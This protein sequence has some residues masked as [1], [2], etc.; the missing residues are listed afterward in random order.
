MASNNSKDI[1]TPSK[2]GQPT[3][4]TEEVMEKLRQAFLI[5]AS[6]REACGFAGIAPSTLYNYQNEHPDYVEQ[7]E[8]WKETPIL[9]AR[10]TISKNLDT[11]DVAKWYLERKKKA[12]FATRHEMT[13][14]DGGPIK[15]SMVEF[16][17]DDAKDQTT[18]DPT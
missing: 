14:D 4:M 11:P 15:T 3:V 10:N 16:V 8:M 12:E 13:G 1:E 2:L 6:D 17:I 7:K 5:G 9:K 18:Q